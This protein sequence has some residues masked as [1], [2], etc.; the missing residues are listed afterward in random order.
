MSCYLDLTCV[1]NSQINYDLHNACKNGNYFCTIMNQPFF[2]RG[3][4]GGK[5]KAEDCCTD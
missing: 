4:G 5:S 1:V 2:W 3:V